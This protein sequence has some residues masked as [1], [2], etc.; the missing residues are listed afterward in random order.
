MLIQRFFFHG[1]A[2]FRLPVLLP[3]LVIFAR[4][5]AHLRIPLQHR[6]DSSEHTP[7]KQQRRQKGERGK[8]TFSSPFIS[9]HTHSLIQNKG[10][11]FQ[12][13]PRLFDFLLFHF[14]L[15]DADGVRMM[16]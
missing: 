2:R 8:W 3:K 16:I 13:V 7:D 10:S 15:N 14:L 9:F 1:F 12:A 6:Q 5:R 11:L 4:F